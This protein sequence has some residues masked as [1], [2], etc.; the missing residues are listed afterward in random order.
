MVYG[1]RAET[2]L[3]G[4][5]SGQVRHARA[6]QFEFETPYNWM[7]LG[8]IY[9]ILYEES[10]APCRSS[11]VLDPEAEDLGLRLANQVKAAKHNLSSLSI[12]DHNGR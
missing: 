2:P 10:D 7:G 4:I 6:V 9:L 3:F 5:H 11:K 12:R 1:K 8:I